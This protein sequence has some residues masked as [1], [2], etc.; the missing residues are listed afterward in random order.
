M[1]LRAV[2]VQLLVVAVIATGALVASPA[3]AAT[4]AATKYA[5]KVHQRVNTIRANH[6]LVRLKKNKCLQRHAA[7]QAARMAKQRRIFHQD[8][9]KIQEACRMGWVGENVATG[10]LPPKQ[11]VR[12]WMNSSGHRANI[13]RKQFRLTGVAARKAGGRWWVAQVFGRRL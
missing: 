12:M 2:T 13:L 9:T 3:P 8:L 4:P 11:I 6:G 5:T 1:S 7:K 10:N